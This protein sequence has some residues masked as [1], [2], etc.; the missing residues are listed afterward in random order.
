VTGGRNGVPPSTT[1]G[2]RD[3][4]SSSTRPGSKACSGQ[5]GAPIET[6]LSVASSAVAISSAKDVSASRALPWTPGAPSFLEVYACR[7]RPP[8]R[9][10]PI[11]AGGPAIVRHRRRRI[12]IGSPINDQQSATRPNPLPLMDKHDSDYAK[13][14]TFASGETDGSAAQPVH[15]HDRR[16]RPASRGRWEQ[17]P[18]AGF[19]RRQAGGLSA[20]SS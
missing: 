5:A 7:Y 16:S 11:V 13:S 10:K 9:R 6:S 1:T 18:D 14:E 8:G 19:A 20:S 3:T 4:R 17:N 2:Q 15:G 12:E